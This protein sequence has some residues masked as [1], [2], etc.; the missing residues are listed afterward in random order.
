MKILS[1]NCRWL[2]RLDKKLAL[3]QIVQS[4]PHDII[5]LQETLGPAADISRSLEHMLLGWKFTGLDA[6]GRSKG[7]SFGYNVCS[8]KLINHWGGTWH[9]GADIFLADIGMNFRIFNIYGLCQNRPEFCKNLLGLDT[10]F[11]DHLI[12]GGDLNFSI[13]HSELWGHCAQRDSLLDYFSTILD[14]HQLIDIPS[15]KI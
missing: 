9:I 11:V 6:H 14:N 2:A 1:F 4:D 5:F 3:H 12:L 15:T 10:F 7:I 8:I 13:G